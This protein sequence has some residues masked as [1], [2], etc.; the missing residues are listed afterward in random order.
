MACSAAKRVVVPPLN[1]PARSLTNALIASGD[2]LANRTATDSGWNTRL[3]ACW[4]TTE[5][6]QAAKDAASI[7]RPSGNSAGEAFSCSS[8]W[9][10][11]E[12]SQ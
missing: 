7:S 8:R 10:I 4:N 1:N 3:T 5:S 9:A 6:A 11:N 12:V 2:S